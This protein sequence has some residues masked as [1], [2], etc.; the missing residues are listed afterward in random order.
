[1]DLLEEEVELGELEKVWLDLLEEEV[2]LGE[3]E[4]VELVELEWAGQEVSED[5]EPNHRRLTKLI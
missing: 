2:E 5:P 4:K 1:M 3:L